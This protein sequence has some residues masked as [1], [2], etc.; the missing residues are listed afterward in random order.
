VTA[1]G[2]Q[3]VNKKLNMRFDVPITR[4]PEEGL[5]EAMLDE[6]WFDIEDFAEALCVARKR[7]QETPQIF[8]TTIDG[9]K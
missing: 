4:I 1:F 7:L 3:A 8:Q 5:A 2:I 6:D 9:G